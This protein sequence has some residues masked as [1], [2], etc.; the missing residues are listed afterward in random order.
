MLFDRTLVLDDDSRV[1]LTVTDHRPAALVIDGRPMGDLLPGDHVT[2]RAATTV[3]HL[4][5]FGPR[6][7]HAIL[8]A[9]F[10]LA[11]R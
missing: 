8:K 1:R 2:C 6:D 7:F 10:G 5:M 9:K 11:D 4:V 3:A